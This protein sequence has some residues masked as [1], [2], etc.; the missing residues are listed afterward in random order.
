M[1]HV[2]MTGEG[3]RQSFTGYLFNASIKVV[4]GWQSRPGFLQVQRKI[5]SR[6]KTVPRQIHKATEKGTYHC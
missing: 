2:L 3:V 1:A 4:K 5:I 6:A